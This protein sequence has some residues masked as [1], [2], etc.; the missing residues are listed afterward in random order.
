MLREYRES[1]FE[2]VK[3]WVNDREATANLSPIFDRVQTEPM[4]RSFFNKALNNELPGHYFVIADRGD[5][6]YIGQIDLRTQDDPSRQAGLGLIVPD[7]ANRGQGIGREAMGLILT[8]AFDTLNL[9]KVWLN[10]FV[11]NIG[12]IGLYR[13]LG[14]STEGVLRDD[15][16]REG[17]YLDLMIMSILAR[18]WRSQ[19]TDR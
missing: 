16:Y 4:T 1:D 14:F 18:E 5:E 7:P 8:F 19:A 10:V 13:S 11:R 3:R 2:H 12:A 6:R 15:V 9:H 17:I